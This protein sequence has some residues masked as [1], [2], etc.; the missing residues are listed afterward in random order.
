[1]VATKGSTT[2]KE[3]PNITPTGRESTNQDPSQGK[4]T[5]RQEE[6][7]PHPAGTKLG[8]YVFGKWLFDYHI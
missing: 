4:K 3:H 6:E 2:N 5:E 1:M 8:H 7:D